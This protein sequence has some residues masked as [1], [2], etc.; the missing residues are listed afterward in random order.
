MREITV[1]G[2]GG[3]SFS[4]IDLA[5][6]CGYSI[7]GLY[8]YNDERTGQIVHG[9]AILGSFDDLFSTDIRGKYFLLTM[10]DMKVRQQLTQRI[11]AAGGIVPTLIH[12]SA[13]VSEFSEISP[14]GVIIESQAIVQSDCIISEGTFICSQAMLCHQVTT[15]PYVFIAPKALLG[16]RLCVGEYSLIGQNAT[17]ISS[18][19][20]EIGRYATIGAGAVVTQP[21]AERMTVVGNPA[22]EL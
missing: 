8:H 1:L 2:I 15:E 20:H 7:G 5:K 14:C 16:A 3:A 18:K 22:R 12:P 17:V 21:V 10:G 11:T 6:T 19:V 4:R 13:Q 9:H